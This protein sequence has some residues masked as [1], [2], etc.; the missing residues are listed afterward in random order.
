MPARGQVVKLIP[1]VVGASSGLRIVAGVALILVGTY[2]TFLTAGAA[3]FLVNLGIGLVVGGVAGMLTKP[4]SFNP[5]ALDKGPSD[6]PSYAFQGAHM[7]TGQGNCVPV[8]YGRCRVGGALISVGISP[9]TWTVNG[10]GGL[11]PD[12]VGTRGGDGSAS[13]WIWAVAPV[14]G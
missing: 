1:A 5:S 9:E 6:T 10:L 8:G 4:P 12:E 14:A 7:T 11:A 3:S 13:P 2:A